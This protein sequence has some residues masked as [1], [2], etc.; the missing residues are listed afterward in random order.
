MVSLD[1]IDVHAHQSAS[2]ENLPTDTAKVTPVAVIGMSCRLPGG[3]D[4]P[5]RLWE[6]LLRGDDLV[7]D[8]PPDRWDADDYYD[9]EP[10][11]QGRSV[12]KWGAFLDDVAGF[13]SEFFAINER[14]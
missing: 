11:M 2:T 6:A 4:S 10:G 8:I 9:P 13:D 7:T 5:E 3:I 1:R 14:E 12:S